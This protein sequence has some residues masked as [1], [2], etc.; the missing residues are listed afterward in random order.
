MKEMDRG[1]G[2]VDI[3]SRRRRVNTLMQP[4]V[5]SGAHCYASFPAG[6][7]DDQ[8][9]ALGLIGQLL[10]TVLVGSEPLPPEGKKIDSGYRPYVPASE[11]NNWIAF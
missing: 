7:H 11:V 10:D 2:A 3:L 9:D 1:S 5:K 4:L 6:R 8:V